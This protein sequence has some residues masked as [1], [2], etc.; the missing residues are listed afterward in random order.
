[1][2]IAY[3]T[4]TYYPQLNGATISIDNFSKAL[5]K[6][7]HKVYIFAPKI[8]GY[9]DEDKDVYRVSSVKVIDSEPEVRMPLLVPNR[10]LRQIFGL[11]FDVV[12]AHGNG[13]FS[14]L[15][16]QAARIKNVPFILTF[17]TIHTKYTHYFL[18]GKI[19]R[20]GVIAAGL[21][22]FANVCDGIIVPS[23]KM[24]Q[25]LTGYKVKKEVKIIPSFIDFSRFSHN[26]KGYLHKKLNIPDKNLILLTVGRLGKEKNFEFL[27]KT[28]KI[29]S[30]KREDVDLV[31]VGHGP[32]EATLKNLTQKLGLRKRVHFTGRLDENTIPL[33]YAD[34]D[35][36]VFASNTETQGVCVL[37]A[38]ASELPLVVVDDPAFENVAIEGKNALKPPLKEREFAKNVLDLVDDG[39]KRERFGKSSVKIAAQNFEPEKLVTQL[40]NYYKVV[41]NSHKDKKRILRRIVDR[42]AF[43][44][45]LKASEKVN[46]FLGLS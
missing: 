36:F 9:E 22:V 37:E 11:D 2:K 34:A 40:E 38:A 41:I 45:L 12:H 32:L 44:Y 27:I 42:K 14:V 10:N 5:R 8:R 26:K 33:A 28:F 6:R 29:L 24:H 3:F 4:D 18:N 15:G 31:I 21:R 1:M 25:E 46:K 30:K 39:I 23:E 17:H 7:G 20:P 16:Y 13:P 35:V 43:V 19:I